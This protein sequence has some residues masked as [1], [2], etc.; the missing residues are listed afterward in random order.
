[1]RNAF[2]KTIT[3]LATQD[4]RV[5]LLSG[6]IGNK[7]FDEFKAKHPKRFFNCGVAEANMISLAAGMAMCGLR[8]FAYTIA[9]FITYRV[10]EQ[11]R[12]D[13][14]YHHLPVTVVGVGAG[15]SYASLGAT[16]HTLEDIAMLRSIPGI[17]VICPG[18]SMEIKAAL[19]ALLKQ[20]DPAYVRIGKK[21]EPVF[22]KEVPSNYQIGK[23]LQIRDGKDISILSTGN[24][25]PSAVTVAEELNKK[26][27]SAAV[28]SFH[29]VKPLDEQTLTQ[30]FQSDRLVC[31][32][33]EHS[34][35]GGFGSAVAEWY[36]GKEKLKAKL[37]RFGTPDSFLHEAG[38]QEHARK[39]CGIEEHQLIEKIEKALS[40]I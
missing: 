30:R 32:L 29:T 22:H 8:P 34:V 33:E 6:D 26:G 28:Y 3:E 39:V 9:S 25:L 15:L 35:I 20:N 16:H 19:P 1:M 14:G 11:I 37:I 36:V 23:S 40:S 24:M 31:T 12:L 18:D 2:A 17:K 5:V 38:E 10:I 7:L 13:A 27:I 4:E 21:G